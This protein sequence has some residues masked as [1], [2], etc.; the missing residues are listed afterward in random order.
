MVQHW[1]DIGKNLTLI[2][3]HFSG[4]IVATL[5]RNSIGFQLQYQLIFTLWLLSFDPRIAQRMIGWE[6][7]QALLDHST[8][9]GLTGSLENYILKLRDSRNVDSSTFWWA[10]WHRKA[11]SSQSQRL[12]RYLFVWAP[13]EKQLVLTFE[14]CYNIR[15]SLILESCGQIGTCGEPTLTSPIVYFSNNAV[16]PVLADILRD[17]DKEKVTRIIIATF[18]VG[19]WTAS[20][21]TG[22]ECPAR[23]ARFACDRDSAPKFHDRRALGRAQK[24]GREEEW[25]GGPCFRALQLSR[26]RNS[27]NSSNHSSLST[28][29]YPF[30]SKVK[31][32]ILPTFL[33][34]NT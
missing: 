33:K 26:Y 24:R 11:P 10:Y 21:V 13:A 20:H 25:E 5:L 4:S 34:R 9:S 27:K 8:A 23:A 3:R 29:T 6:D 2:S 31:K 16:I 30:T 22:S 7:A 1:Y 28:H 19:S 32:Y 17:S 18:R 12:E 14:C 15:S